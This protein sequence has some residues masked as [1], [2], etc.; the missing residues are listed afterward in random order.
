M[1][2]GVPVTCQNGHK[3][4][5]VIEIDGLDII[6]HGVNRVVACDCPKICVG[7]GYRAAGKP[8]VI[9]NIDGGGE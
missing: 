4:T 1:K 6:E 9:E 5:W 3:A 8:Y 2:I 7:Q